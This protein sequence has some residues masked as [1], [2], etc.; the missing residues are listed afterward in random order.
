MLVVECN[1]KN[2]YNFFLSFL[3]MDMKY[4]Y[5][6]LLAIILG[7]WWWMKSCMSLH[8]QQILQLSKIDP[9]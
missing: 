5:R 2:C 9:T 8:Q 4:S 3:G 7:I 1:D 6:W